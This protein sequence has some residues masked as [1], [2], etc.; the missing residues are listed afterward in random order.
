MIFKTCTILEKASE[1]INRSSE[2]A[3]LT[4]LN[5]PFL[6]DLGG[7]H[8]HDNTIIVSAYYHKFPFSESMANSTIMLVSFH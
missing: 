3:F 7:K 8:Y 6:I 2:N 1:T 5:L 4:S